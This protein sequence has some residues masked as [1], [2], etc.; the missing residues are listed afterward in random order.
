MAEP[1]W[2]P[3]GY[4]G[5]LL[6]TPR[7][8]EARVHAYRDAYP[9]NVRA[10]GME[11]EEDDC[12]PLLLAALRQLHQQGLSVELVHLLAVHEDWPEAHGNIAPEIKLHEIGEPDAPLVTA[13]YQWHPTAG[14]A[15]PRD[16]TFADPSGT[17]KLQPEPRLLRQ[18][19][20]ALLDAGVPACVG[21]V[22][23]VLFTPADELPDDRHVIRVM[24]SGPED[25]TDVLSW[26]TGVSVDGVGDEEAIPY[27]SASV[28]LAHALGVRHDEVWYWEADYGLD[29]A[30]IAAWREQH[31]RTPAW[32]PEW[33]H[34]Y[35]HGWRHVHALPPE[36]MRLYGARRLGRCEHRGGLDGE[37]GDD[38][39]QRPFVFHPVGT[40]FVNTVYCTDVGI[41]R[42]FHWD[43]KVGELTQTNAPPAAAALLVAVGLGE[44]ARTFF[45]NQAA[46]LQRSVAEEAPA[47]LATVNALLAALA[48]ECERVA[49]ALREQ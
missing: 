40:D 5:E 49:A 30:E 39:L 7:E 23:S 21:S 45:S 2:E 47:T 32:P 16:V 29:V 25:K 12:C 4:D 38:G 24:K 8:A 36:L 31:G 9:E 26:E 3:R 43:R 17:H 41:E 6:C 15:I 20:V 19:L 48:D 37:P 11:I 46:A 33:N 42:T 10:V 14:H 13:T 35:K 1:R 44:R 27:V 18:V 22:T 28:R 34:D